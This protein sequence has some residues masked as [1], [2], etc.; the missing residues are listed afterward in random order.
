MKSCGGKFFFRNE[1][2]RKIIRDKISQTC[3]VGTI[4]GTI[5]HPI[6]SFKMLVTIPLLNKVQEVRARVPAALV[7]GTMLTPWG[8]DTVE[9]SMCYL[10]SGMRGP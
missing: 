5:R 1:R 3:A 9:A 10:R 4:V 2:G 8:A 6:Q 7:G